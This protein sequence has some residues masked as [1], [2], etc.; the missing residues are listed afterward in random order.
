MRKGI[1]QTAILLASGSLLVVGCSNEKPSPSSTSTSVPASAS[2]S[3]A[4]TPSVPTKIRLFTSDNSQP[5][6][7]ADDSN[8][9]YLEKKTNTDLDIVTLPH[10]QYADQL[11]LKFA[12]GDFPDVYQSWSG[13]D[14]DLVASGKV[15]ELNA[16]IDKYGPNLKKN[17]P[18]ASWDAVSVNGK[19]LAIPQP[20]A[21]SGAVTYVRKDWLDKLGLQ[22]PKTSDELMTVL[23]AFRDKDPNGNGKKDEIPYSMREKLTW[24]ENLFGM[25]G[26]NQQWTEVLYNN[27]VILQNIHP[28]MKPAISYIK[29]MVDEKVMD[30]EFLTNSR[31][32][33]E[34]KIRS[35][36]VGMWTHSIGLAWQWQSDLDK[37]LP[38]EKPNVIAIP[39]PRGTGYTGPL[40]TRWSPVGK[41]YIVMKN[42]K[43]PEAIIKYFDWL[44]SD[45]GQMLTDL[46]QEG[47]S[48]KK[49]NGKI[50]V[51]A[52]KIEK[53]A[54]FNI[55]FKLHDT[56]E[57]VEEAK[58]NNP[59]AY[60]KL[61][62][63][64]E[65]ASKEGYP[66]ESVGM[67]PAKESYNIATMYL[68][69]TS[70]ILLGK[71]PI[72]SFDEFVKTWR[73]QGGD[74]MVKERTDWYNKN[75]KK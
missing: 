51:D 46:G 39:T 72:D 54:P 18:Q 8:V 41:T 66:S 23:K 14:S 29:S 19:I 36:V 60:G 25:W 63:A 1:K 16:L 38:N 21:F 74:Q 70:K 17:I 11:T 50:V 52:A 4:P 64:R 27:E 7:A 71:E 47:D 34:Q 3:A 6:V 67:P 5:P 73:K 20:I 69:A 57:A 42:T 62:T 9:L 65:I 45:E 40:G 10:A 24:G 56:N 12:S 43:N 13:P 58:L 33:W 22:V 35:G 68:E 61:K 75:R 28:N 2:A 26:V 32:I 53:L 31:A 30:S 49:E 15:L 37:A 48:Y 44:M 59:V 55:M